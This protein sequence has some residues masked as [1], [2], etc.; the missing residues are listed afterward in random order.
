M[1]EKSLPLEIRFAKSFLEHE[2]GIN[3]LWI[4]LAQ[5][6]GVKHAEV[7]LQLPKGIYWT[8]DAGEY[9]VGADRQIILESL[10]SPSELL[11]EIYTLQPI[12][13][14]L[15][16]LIITVSCLEESG[17]EREH[18]LTV[19]LMISDEE[20]A[21]QPAMDDEI[22]RKVKERFSRH[23]QH[24]DYHGNKELLDCTPGRLI[25]YD[26]H[27]QSELEKKYRVEGYY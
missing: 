15:T 2:E 12:G 8:G 3:H 11:L 9:P 4:R 7:R 19:P 22:V 5:L 1:I 16:E 13:C 20:E 14:G 6:T 26:P 24:P 18:S 23:T 27:Y 10:Q 21:G 17:E 25:R